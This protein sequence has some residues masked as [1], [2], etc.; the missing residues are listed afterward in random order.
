VP[1]SQAAHN[2]PLLPCCS[3]VL[4]KLWSDKYGRSVAGDLVDGLGPD[5]AAW[6]AQ[7]GHQCKRSVS[8]AGEMAPSGVWESVKSGSLCQA[9]RVTAH[10]LETGRHCAYWWF[11]SL[12]LWLLRTMQTR[13]HMM[14]T[15]CRCRGS[16]S[17]LGQEPPPL[18][19]IQI[20]RLL[21]QALAL[22]EGA[23][24]LLAMEVLLVIQ[25][26]ARALGLRLLGSRAPGL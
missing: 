24:G 19:N 5:L 25:V 13:C 14:P 3:F 15:H 17:D 7:L 10:C 20:S 23:V 2:W 1:L 18:R 12:F 8:W 21:Q 26:G 4:L 22:P 6:W 9:H 11:R 16:Q